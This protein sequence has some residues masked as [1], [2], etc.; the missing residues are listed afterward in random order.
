MK[1]TV[2]LYQIKEQL[3]H[4]IAGLR[5]KSF[6]VWQDNDKIKLQCCVIHGNRTI[7]YYGN[8]YEVIDMNKGILQVSN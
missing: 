5:N 3:Q 7:E 1:N 6:R 2:E 4:K 8:I